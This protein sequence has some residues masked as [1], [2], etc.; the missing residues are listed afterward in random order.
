M[1]RLDALISGSF[2][3]QFFDGVVWEESVLDIYIHETKAAEL[4]HYLVTEEGY[5]LQVSS[6][7]L[8]AQGCPNEA[9]LVKVGIPPRISHHNSC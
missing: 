7:L 9:D 4:G 2:V 6:S 1:G 5:E 3:I 8:D